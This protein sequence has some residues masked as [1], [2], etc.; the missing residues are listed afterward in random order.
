MSEAR[1]SV[2]TVRKFLG[3]SLLV[4]LDAVNLFDTIF[5]L[6]GNDTGADDA[7]F[8]HIHETVGL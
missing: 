8:P 2:E 1:V 5:V 6:L 3:E 7:Y 4:V